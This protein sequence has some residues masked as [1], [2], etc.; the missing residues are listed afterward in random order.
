[1]SLDDHKEESCESGV[2]CSWVVSS[3]TRWEDVA[4]LEREAEDDA[5]VES[6][7]PFV[8]EGR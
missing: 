7:W 8:L 4:P 2:G 1:V 3:I 5:A 6:E